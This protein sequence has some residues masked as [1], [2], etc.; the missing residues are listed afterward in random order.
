MFASHRTGTLLGTR[1]L[2]GVSGGIAAY[3]SAVLARLLKKAGAEVR[4]VMTEG[5]QAF[6]KPLTFQALTGEPVGTSLLDPEAEA[7][8]GHIELARWAELIL[9]APASA[10]LIARLSRGHADDL[11]TTLCLGSGAERMLAPAM[12]Q[13]MWAHPAVQ[14]NVDRLKTQGWG[15]LGPDAGEQACGDIGSG[16]MM[17]PEA[18][19]D[20]LQ[21]SPGQR[22]AQGLEIV[23]T[24]GPTREA[25]DPVRYLTNHS[26]GKMGYALAAAAQALGATVTLISGPVRLATPPGVAR[27]D[28]DSAE[29]ML[30]AAERAAATADIFIAAAAVADYRPATAAEQKIKKGSED[31]LVLRLIKNPDVVATI[32]ARENAPFTVGFAAETEA[33]ERHALDKLERKR[34]MMIV[35]NQVGGGLGFDRDDNAA[36]LYWREPKQQIRSE[37]FEA[38]PKRALAEKLI[39]RI[40]AHYRSATS[41]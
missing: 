16:R 30:D 39:L 40:V 41:A 10:N 17:E 27:V 1:I 36:T 11:L 26:S 8:M 13:Q 37:R 20:T 34:L 29:Q 2:L 23:I 33:L 14:E 28:V 19:I 31:E 35:A 7:G 12:N 25:I 24:A 21:A 15:I 5:A 3:K 9:I 6:I 22:P 4:V 38:Q 32:A 18:I